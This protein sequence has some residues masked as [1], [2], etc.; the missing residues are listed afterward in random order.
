MIRRFGFLDNAGLA[1]F[2]RRGIEAV[3]FG[4]RVA[5]L[6]IAVALVGS[7]QAA[8]AQTHTPEQREDVASLVRLADDAMLADVGMAA[9]AAAAPAALRFGLQD[10]RDGA[11]P[12]SWLSTHFIK[13]QQ[14]RTYVPFTVTVD[15]ARLG[16]GAAALLVRIVSA[17]QA[18]AF[19]R[20]RALAPAEGAQPPA[21]PTYAWDEAYFLD[22]PGDGQF[23][24]AVELPPGRYVAYIAIKPPSQAPAAAGDAAAAEG[25]T[26]LLRHEL[27]VPDYAAQRLT[28]SSIILAR[29]IQQLDA[30]LPPAQ[31]A[32]NP[33]VLGTLRIAPSV[34]RSFTKASQLNFLF[35]IYGVEAGPMGKPDVTLEYTFH[36][37]L[38]EGET[39]FNKT[40]PQT[41]NA[42]TLAPQFSLEAGHQL[43]GGLAIPLGT[44]PEGEYRLEIAV[45][46][47]VS[48]NRLIES[49]EFTVQPA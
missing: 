27:T 3:M 46:D 31:Q 17:E 37:R 20:T 39:Y 30:P 18:A 2:A 26:G 11:I 19:A 24:R 21:P 49:V 33:Y 5:F 34:N 22:V 8:R 1:G 35:W 15:R 47:N 28:T 36:R 43:T 6:F 32:E 7:A 41:L 44:F 25:P 29:S 14:G 48:G 40:A 16:G 4:R 23:A 13:G 45:T 10:R 42:E 12:V 9:G 38:E